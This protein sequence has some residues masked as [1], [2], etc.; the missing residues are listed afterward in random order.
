MQLPDLEEM[1]VMTQNRKPCNFIKSF[2]DRERQQSATELLKLLSFGA[3]DEKEG[4]TL[5][6]DQ[7]LNNL[8][9]KYL[10]NK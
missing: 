5:S 2:E 1:I 3:I 4:K 6:G 9:A 7:V 8:R 10:D